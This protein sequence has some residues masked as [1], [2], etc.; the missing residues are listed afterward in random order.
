MLHRI[1]FAKNDCYFLVRPWGNLIIYPYRESSEQDTQHFI[2]KGGVYRQLAFNSN[3]ISPGQIYLFH[4]F[5]A[6][7]VT[8]KTV[9]YHPE[10]KIE[11]NGVEFYDPYIDF[12]QQGEFCAIKVGVKDHTYYFFNDQFNIKDGKLVVQNSKAHQ[13]AQQFLQQLNAKKDDHLFCPKAQGHNYH[14]ILGS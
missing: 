9:E 3:S 13:A 6:A 4:K 11:Q 5:G 8:P 12:I 14:K 7:L 1:Y 2:S 10:I